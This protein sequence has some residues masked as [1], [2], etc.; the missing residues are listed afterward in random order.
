MHLVDTDQGPEPPKQIPDFPLDDSA[1]KGVFARWCFKRKNYPGWI[2]LGDEKR[3]QIWEETK[4][5]IGPLLNRV[6]G[7][8]A[9]DRVLLFRE[10]N[11]RLEI[12]MVVPRQKS[13]QHRKPLRYERYVV[14]NTKV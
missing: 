13:I 7:L 11:W 10:I 4:Y 3:Q 2:V 1:I 6:Q 12:S 9:L 8:K 14:R 5:W